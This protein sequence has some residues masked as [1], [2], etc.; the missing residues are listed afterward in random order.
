MEIV[1]KKVTVNISDMQLDFEKTRN[2]LKA[3]FHNLSCKLDHPHISD[4]VD[5]EFVKI[6]EQ[7]TKPKLKPNRRLKSAVVKTQIVNHFQK[8]IEVSKLKISN[9]KQP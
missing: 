4:T 6:V 3:D 9:T 8:K 5:S 7:S 2:E 1:R